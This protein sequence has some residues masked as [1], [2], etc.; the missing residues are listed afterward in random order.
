MYPNYSE[1]VKTGHSPVERESVGHSSV[2]AADSEP[3]RDLCPG[4]LQSAGAL[5]D[6]FA[7]QG[8][9]VPDISVI[10]SAAGGMTTRENFVRG[11]RQSLT[12]SVT[13]RSSLYECTRFAEIAADRWPTILSPSRQV[14]GVA[15]VVVPHFFNAGQSRTSFPSPPLIC[16]ASSSLLA[17]QALCPC[18]YAAMHHVPLEDECRGVV[19][20]S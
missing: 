6:H 10:Q 12:T 8:T 20:T 13:P 4:S 18:H 7:D 16:V 15:D 3:G 5:H 9:K 2:P 19:T 17:R 1:N 14:P 11:A